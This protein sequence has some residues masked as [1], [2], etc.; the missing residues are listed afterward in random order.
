MV[1]RKTLKAFGQDQSGASAVEYG[2][3]TALVSI[4]GIVALQAMGV[5]LD[6]I[7]TGVSGTLD[8]SGTQAAGGTGGAAGGN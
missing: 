7:F 1:D 3:I 2:L 8:S 6:T 4:A 5:S